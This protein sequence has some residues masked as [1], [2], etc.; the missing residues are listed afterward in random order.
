MVTALIVSSPALYGN[1]CHV[2]TVGSYE[3]MNKV[4][5]A[6][7][8]K[9]PVYLQVNMKSSQLSSTKLSTQQPN[10]LSCVVLARSISPLNFKFTIFRTES[11]TFTT[12]SS[13]FPLAFSATKSADDRSS[14]YPQLVRISSAIRL[15]FRLLTSEREGM[16]VFW[17]LQTVCFAL[18][19]TRGDLAAAHTFIAMI[20]EFVQL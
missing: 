13:L 14:S 3:D 19:S 6:I 20:C 9:W 8:S 10:S 4:L 18:Y 15:E 2:L 16:F 7:G 12:S 5:S 11:S 1:E 17:T